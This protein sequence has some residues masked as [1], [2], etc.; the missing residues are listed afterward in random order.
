M[1]QAFWSR[2][3]LSPAL[4]YDLTNLLTYIYDANVIEEMTSALGVPVGANTTFSKMDATSVIPPVVFAWTS[5]GLTVIIGGT[6]GRMHL[7]ELFQGWNDPSIGPDAQYGASGGFAHAARVILEGMP[8]SFWLSHNRIYLVGH[9]YG[10]ACAQALAML[11]KMGQLPLQGVWSYGA[12]RP[13]NSVMQ[14]YMETIPNYRFWGSDDPVRFIPPHSE[15]VSL[16][17]TFGNFPLVRGCNSQVQTP[18]G[19]RLDPLGDIVPDSG[20]P[21]VLHA[22]GLSVYN[23]CFDANGFRS[24]LHAASEYRR[25]FQQGMPI[26][27]NGPAIPRSQ[28]EEQPGTLRPREIAQ[29]ERDAIPLV[30]VELADPTSD[31][32]R[33]I[34][35]LPTVVPNVRFRRRKDGAV[36]VVKYGDSIVDVGPGKRKAGQLA[37]RYNKLM[38][39]R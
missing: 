32:N 25:R 1:N 24:V 11:L 13:G 14:R 23:W 20:N 30:K 16:L 5:W 36:W 6:S 35:S 34:N 8:G 9:S 28:V 2:P 22:V 10:G 17:D 21:T 38:A 39:T 12:P 18:I 27:P 15:E 4:N 26:K 29:Q 3:A 31:L 33:E 37:R 7:Q 19:Y